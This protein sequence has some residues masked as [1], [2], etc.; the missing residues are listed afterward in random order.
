M[1][2]DGPGQTHLLPGKFDV[3]LGA[4]QV[5]GV[6]TRNSFAA[7]LERTTGLPVV[8]L[9]RGAAGPHIYT[10]A[11]SWPALAPL[12]TNARAVIICVMAGRSSPSTE[13]GAFSG[14]S[15]GA[16]QIRAYDRVIALERGGHRQHSE[17]LQQESLRSARQDYKELVRR[18]R[19]GGAVAGALP[20]RVLLVWFSGCSIRGCKETWQYPQYFTS[21]KSVQALQR[22]T[23]AELVDA[24]YGH[25]PPSPPI[26]IDQ[27]AS[28]VPAGRGQCNSVV[29][30][31]DGAQTGRLCGGYCGRVQDWYYPDDAAHAHAASLLQHVLASPEVSAA[32]VVAEAASLPPI[33][34][35]GGGRIFFHHVHKASGTAFLAFL[36]SMEGVSDCSAFGITSPDHVTPTPW[37]DFARWWHEPRLPLVGGECNLASIETPELGEMLGKLGVVAPSAMD[38]VTAAEA[39]APQMLSF[40]RHP[41]SRC[42]SH[43][44]YEQALCRRRALGVH[45]PFCTSYFLP[46]YGSPERLNDTAA[47]AAFAAEHCTELVTRSLT[48]Q[49]GVPSP[50]LLL[51]R[52]FAFFGL[53]ERFLESVCLFLYQVWGSPLPTSSYLPL[54]LLFLISFSTTQADRFRRD[55]C[56]CASP[57]TPIGAA[58]GTPGTPGADERPGLGIERELLPPDANEAA[59]LRAGAVGV[60][61]LMLS[62]AELAARSPRDMELYASLQRVFKR[63]V[64]A[65][66]ARVNATVWGCVRA[67]GGR[68]GGRRLSSLFSAGR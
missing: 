43:W 34:L 10:D 42:R 36:A 40:L 31:Q 18:I 54:S 66:E 23:G 53:Q 55:L 2:R 35:G 30:R 1:P 52:R 51:T 46:N 28:C 17:R 32:D 24:S 29:A 44:K 65:M 37:A 49:H 62:D 20:P 8:N 26:P 12:L 33:R 11:G 47:H 22:A 25:L 5:V 16:E 41:V 21:E 59:L 60:P 6:L 67:D 61:P 9:G 56:T 15:F 7:Q 50:R 38:A 58:D 3:V 4:A 27:C 19:S 68:M 63:R 64:H 39:G 13:S 57:N 48:A 14:Q 45:A